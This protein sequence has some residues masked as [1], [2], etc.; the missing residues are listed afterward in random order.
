MSDPRSMTGFGRAEGAWRGGKITVEA[1]SLNHRY[2]EVRTKLPRELAALEPQV[3]EW[4]RG[5]IP[6][7]R[8]DVNAAIHGLTQ[9]ISL[10][11]LNMPLAMRYVEMYRTLAEQMNA[12]T[13]INPALILTMG[14]V[15]LMQEEAVDL[16]AEWKS[17]RPVF[18]A[19]F[20][21]LD[22]SANAEGAKL[23][24]DLRKRI[25]HI[26]EM[27]DRMIQL[28]PEELVAYRGRLA[29]RIQQLSERP[30]I[31]EDRLA[32]E[33]AYYA[34]RCDFTEESVRL[35]AHI[36]RFGEILD[37]SGS[38]GRSLDFLTQEMLREIN[39]TSSKA[40]SAEI[41]QIAVEVKAE[42]EKIREQV[43][44]IE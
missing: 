30:E 26:A 41:S 3:T 10:P 31:N 25:Q 19:A 12:P 42:L 37:G 9:P 38:R 15:I 43:Q 33:L 18:E 34:E 2:L 32:Q 11:V 20:E 5:R 40:L 16:E 6:R 35:K 23:A 8:I 22:S 14:D 17:I 21:A 13:D 7:G 28:Q 36:E 4:V 29:A 1:R 27:T 24:T 44:N 39:T